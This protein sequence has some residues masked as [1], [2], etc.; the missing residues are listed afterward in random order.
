MGSAPAKPSRNEG[1]YFVETDAISISVSDDEDRPNQ[2]R[3]F[4]FT[5]VKCNSFVV[6]WKPPQDCDVERYQVR[7]FPPEGVKSKSL[8]NS[9]QEASYTFDRLTSGTRYT[10]GVVLV[11]I[12]KKKSTCAS[13]SESTLPQPPTEIDFPTSEITASTFRVRWRPSKGD[14]DYYEAEITPTNGVTGNTS[15]TNLLDCHHVFTGLVPGTE[16]NVKVVSVSNDRKSEVLEKSVIT[17]PGHVYDLSFPNV[18]HNEMQLVW[19]PPSGIVECY[20]L[21]LTSEIE[22]E[23]PVV[24]EKI[25][26]TS[27][28]FNGLVTGRNY[29]CEIFTHALGKTSL[30][31]R[32]DQCTVPSEIANLSVAKVTVD[33]VVLTWSNAPGDVEDYDLFLNPRDG[34]IGDPCPRGIVGTTHIFKGLL[35][36]TKYTVGVVTN[37]KDKMSQRVVTGFLTDPA[38]CGEISFPSDELKSTQI[39]VH[40]LPA[41]GE[42]D[43]YSILVIKD[44]GSGGS[45]KEEDITQPRHIFTGL[46]PGAEYAFTITTIREGRHS[47]SKTASC[48][49]LPC[50]AGNIA[51]PEG[52][53]TSN[54]IK[55]IWHPSAG[56]VD[57]YKIQAKGGGTR[58]E[59]Y[60]KYDKAE[61][62]ISNLLPGTKYDIAVSVISYGVESEPSLATCMTGPDCVKELTA[63]TLSK[64]EIQVSWLPPDGGVDHFELAIRPP[65][66]IGSETDPTG[67]T[68]H[69]H[70]FERLVPGTLYSVWVTPIARGVRGPPTEVKAYT[71]PGDVL[72]VHFPTDCITSESMKIAWGVEGNSKDV[73]ATLTNV[74]EGEFGQ[75]CAVPI[76]KET[77]KSASQHVFTELTEGTKYTVTLQAIASPELSQAG[78]QNAV[79]A[80]IIANQETGGNRNEAATA[81]NNEE[82]SYKD[83]SESTTVISTRQAFVEIEDVSTC[84]T[85]S[86]KS[87]DDIQTENKDIAQPSAPKTET[88]SPSSSPSENLPLI[89]L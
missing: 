81:N 25:K 60:A 69:V 88:S 39:G 42:C 48:S 79:G 55:V 7:I 40:W 22:A 24:I 78:G 72:N 38:S 18:T 58:F 49:T 75:E 83:P 56:G 5:D 31:K 53:T 50:P 45:W 29:S 73:M 74:Y 44:G 84:E 85:T 82:S 12:N 52:G 20:T 1:L 57:S 61:F 27:Y 46:T 76:S 4:G 15:V 34:V 59:D 13:A 35:P 66:G 47:V 63:K 33:E 23:E 54:S 41:R 37:S 70:V 16:Y 28:K 65:K 30:R 14:R 6:S 77:I 32:F 67:I 8:I 80:A 51:F 21:K 26:Q 64:N 36:G 43:S 3:G 68:S 2:V 89:E 62:T 10:V 9:L 17:N 19:K 86:K 11:D 71:L 87:E